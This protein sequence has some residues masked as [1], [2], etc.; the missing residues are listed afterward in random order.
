[1]PNRYYLNRPRRP[2]ASSIGG[3]SE[4]AVWSGSSTMPATRS[5][6]AALGA[7]IKSRRVG[8]RFLLRSG[9]TGYEGRQR[10]SVRPKAPSMLLRPRR[11]ANM[12]AV[13]PVG[14]TSSGTQSASRSRRAPHG[15]RWLWNMRPQ[16]RRYSVVRGAVAFLLFLLP[17]PSDEATPRAEPAH[18]ADEHDEGQR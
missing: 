5:L 9:S 16:G 18:E 3:D 10:R 6:F 15:C 17:K 1:M 8:A 11:R 4:A 7:G 12:M 13:G 2:E 14:S